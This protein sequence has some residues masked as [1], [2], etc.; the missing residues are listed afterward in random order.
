MKKAFSVVI[1]VLL[2]FSLCSAFSAT[3]TQQQVIENFK[4]GLYI[5]DW[6]PC[7][8][9]EETVRDMAEC[10]IQYTFLWFFS[11]KDPEKVQQLEWCRKYGIKVILKDVDIEIYLGRRLEDVRDTT[12]E[13]IYE[14]IKPSIGDPTIIGYN[15]YDEPGESGYE[16]LAIYLEKFK[17]VAQ[18]MIPFVN[19]YPH[20]YGSYIDRCITTLKQDY[21]SVDIYP[22]EGQTTDERYY[23]N[24]KDVGDSARELGGDFWLFMQ[25]M[26]FKGRRRPDIYDLRFQAYSAISFGA[27]KLMHFCYSNPFGDESYAAVNNGVKSDLYPVLQQ[28]NAEMQHLSS[29]LCQYSDQ[30]AFF[31]R[32][33]NLTE[34]DEPS[35]FFMIDGL[36]QYDDFR[37]LKTI[38]SNQYILMGAFNHDANDLKKG[39]MVVN[40]SD[41]AKEE[42]ADV[43]FT[44]RYSDKP[45]SVTMEG[46]TFSLSADEDGIY[47]LHLGA[48]GGA[49][50]E[51]EERER[52]EQEKLEDQY[53]A[54]CNA[55]KNL[56][57][58]MAIDQ[59]VYDTH[60]FDVMEAT[61]EKYAEDLQN[62]SL[63]FEE[64]VLAREDLLAARDQVKT[65]MEIAIALS[66]QVRICYSQIEP[67]LFDLKSYQALTAYM[68][69][70][71]NEL[72]AETVT[73]NRVLKVAQ[74]IDNTLNTMVF[75][76]L[77]GDMN[78]DGYVTLSDVMIAARQ[79]VQIDAFNYTAMRIGDMNGDLIIQLSDI[80]IIAK[81]VMQAE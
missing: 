58:Q 44:L 69:T 8:L 46:K 52:T 33:Q 49:F 28:F 60:S 15:I 35:Y 67:E 1:A 9:T 5:G 57:K 10:G 51:V 77:S 19:L 36:P 23:Y 24:L 38:T 55:V 13:E 12:P 37:T 64:L 48:G 45:V 30:G 7:V 42:E 53:Y 72:N 14:I 80:L 61:V 25:S 56:Y 74:I 81:T 27:T 16:E 3:E 11:Y 18:G 21:I 22:L 41:V 20:L 73:A 40:A 47:H 34:H 62:S 75:T 68:R 59:S 2:V 70:L 78:K 50:I 4:R 29:A 79:V 17:S 31:I 54:D 65:V 71:E 76:G 32:G 39:L 63:T 6:V 66:E 43:A 26:A